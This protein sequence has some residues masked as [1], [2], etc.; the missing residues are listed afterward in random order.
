[1]KFFYFEYLYYYK[2]KFLAELNTNI[3]TRLFKNIVKK[4]YNYF[5]KQTTPNLM[6]IIGSVDGFT[7]G[8]AYSLI[9][10]FIDSLTLIL[11]LVFLFS[12]NF[13]ATILIFS[14]LVIISLIYSSIFKKKLI[15]RQRKNFFMR[16]L[17]LRISKIVLM[18]SKK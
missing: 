13:K 9:L 3:S 7:F 4:P 15:I 2:N 17:L 16:V 8:I 6:N 14:L 11:F 18:E 10:I 5:I 1:M 12:F